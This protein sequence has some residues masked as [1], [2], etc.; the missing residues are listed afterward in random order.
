MAVLLAHGGCRSLILNVLGALKRAGR[1]GHTLST[2]PLPGTLGVQCDEDRVLLAEVGL[3]E[4]LPQVPLRSL[5]TCLFPLSALPPAL[6]ETGNLAEQRQPPHTPARDYAGNE[7]ILLV[8]S[9]LGAGLLMVPF[10]P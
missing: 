10:A 2:G 9:E 1:K 6:V 8:P 4:G 7:I 5:G 3:C